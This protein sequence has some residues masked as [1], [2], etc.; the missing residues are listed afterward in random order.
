MSYDEI[1]ALFGRQGAL[2]QVVE[3]PQPQHGMKGDV[4]G[5][6]QYGRSVVQR[7]EYE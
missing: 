6:R 4:E 1:S 2:R 5:M 3:V 7:F